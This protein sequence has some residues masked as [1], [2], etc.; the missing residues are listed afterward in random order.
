MAHA[1]SGLGVIATKRLPRYMRRHT[2]AQRPHARRLPPVPQAGG[3]N[4]RH[5]PM[6]PGT[7]LNGPATSDVIHPP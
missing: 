7:P 1:A 6:L 3:Q 5:H 4:G 2:A